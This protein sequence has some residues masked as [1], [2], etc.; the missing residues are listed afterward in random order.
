MKLD[1]E[2][3][4]EEK[5]KREVINIAAKTMMYD[6]VRKHGCVKRLILSD[7]FSF[8]VVDDLKAHHE[9][10]K[11]KWTERKF[12]IYMPCWTKT[13]EALWLSDFVFAP[14][15]FENHW[16]CY[17]L[18]HRKR[19]IYVLDSLYNERNGPRQDNAMK[20]R[21]EGVVEFMNKVP[22]NKANMLAPSLEVVVVDLPKQKN[23]H[24]CGVYVLKYLELWDGQ[25]KWGQKIMI[26]AF[27]S[28]STWSCGMVKRNGGRRVCPTIHCHDCGVYVLKYLELW[29]GQA[30]WGQK[31]MIVAFMSLSTWSCG[32][33][34]R[35][36]GRRVCPTIHCHDCGV[37]VLKYLEL[38]DGQAKWGQKSMPDYS[39]VM[40]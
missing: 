24:D 7:Y 10:R 15:H 2:D 26:V 29:D 30:K 14:T 4:A 36:G 21:F 1:D 35:N 39:L 22:N 23:C 20:V 11:L 18:D 3:I 33:V 28:L 40:L 17:V 13:L 37:Y 9:G 34:K 8:E 25:A 12:K 27:M 6:E 38:W 31:I 32:M 5:K 19:K 16:T